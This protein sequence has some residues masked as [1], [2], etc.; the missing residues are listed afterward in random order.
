MG[1]PEVP[2]IPKLVGNYV[3]KTEPNTPIVNITEDRLYRSL[4]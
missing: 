3:D 4:W 1:R 2:A